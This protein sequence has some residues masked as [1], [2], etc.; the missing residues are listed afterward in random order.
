LP[1]AYEKHHSSFSLLD[2]RGTE[3][4]IQTT[5]KG[6]ESNYHEASEETWYQQTKERKIEEGNVVEGRWR[7]RGV[8]KG[9]DN[10]GHKQE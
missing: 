3:K 4:P 8:R 1:Y 10:T 6:E 7:G 5:E 9:K 2:D